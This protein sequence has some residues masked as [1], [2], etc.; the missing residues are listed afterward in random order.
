VSHSAFTAC[1][2]AR[3][4]PLLSIVAV[5]DAPFCWIDFSK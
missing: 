1:S 4:A 3:L 5:S 2:A